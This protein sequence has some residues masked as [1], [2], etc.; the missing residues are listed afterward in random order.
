MPPSK[1][2]FHHLALGT[3]GQAGCQHNSLPL[4]TNPTTQTLLTYTQHRNT[5]TK[6]HAIYT[7]R[8]IEEK[9]P[10]NIARKIST[11]FLL[12]S[13]TSCSSLTHCRDQN[14]ERD[15]CGTFDEGMACHA[16]RRSCDKRFYYEHL[17]N[18]G[19]TICSCDTELMNSEIEAVN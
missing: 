11:I 6:T 18:E 16:L 19:R 5:F 4:N 10:M 12:F 9:V 13:I 1:Q 2:M 15:Y 7:I 8:T 14:A 3:M 17:N